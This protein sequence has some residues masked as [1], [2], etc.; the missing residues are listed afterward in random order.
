M[1]PWTL[2]N[3]DKERMNAILYISLDLISKIAILLDPIIPIA[4]KKVLDA[5]NVPKNLRNLS[6]IKKD[7]A[8][9]K[10]I[11]INNLDILFKKFN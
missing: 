10:E 5:L 8:L 6:F 2:K 7:G 3:K 4:S 9:Q 11:I 1:E